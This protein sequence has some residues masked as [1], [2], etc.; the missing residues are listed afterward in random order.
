NEPHTFIE[1]EVR[2]YGMIAG[3]IEEVI[4]RKLRSDERRYLAT[5]AQAV[6]NPLEYSAQPTEAQPTEVS[7][8]DLKPPRMARLKSAIGQSR[9]TRIFVSPRRWMRRLR[10]V[11]WHIA[12][13]AMR[14]KFSLPQPLLGTVRWTWAPLLIAATLITV[15]WMIH[16]GE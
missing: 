13:P 16:A 15:S 14:T 11:F 12:A 3:F 10:Y 9:L 7:G 4:A 8:Y 2:A 1:P 5:P 6:P